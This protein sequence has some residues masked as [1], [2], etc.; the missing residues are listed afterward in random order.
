MKPL[1]RRF[2]GGTRLLRSSAACIAALAG[3]SGVAV[4]AQDRLDGA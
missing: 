3:L 1:D 4:N 2:N